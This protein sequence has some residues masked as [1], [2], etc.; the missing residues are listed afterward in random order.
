MPEHHNSDR[1]EHDLRLWIAAGQHGIFKAAFSVE[2]QTVCYLACAQET[3]PLRMTYLI[4]HP[5]KPILYGILRGEGFS[6]IHAYQI[7]DNGD[8][9]LINSLDDCPAG[10][11]HI[12]INDE[13]SLLVVAYYLSGQAGIYAILP[14]GALG[15]LR[16]EIHHSGSSHHPERQTSP[17]PHWT[18]FSLN[19]NSF[20]VTDLGIDQICCYHFKNNQLKLQQKT[21][22]TQGAGPRHMAFHKASHTAYVTNELQASVSA[23][24]YNPENG[25]L[26]EI[27]TIK[28]FV[29]SEPE[30][31]HNVSDIKIHPSGQFLYVLNRGVDLISVF[32]VA[33]KTGKLTWIASEPAHS[34]SSRSITFDA[35]GHLMFVSGEFSDTVVIFHINSNTGQLEWQPPILTVP[36]PMAIVTETIVFNQG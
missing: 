4:K 14:S 8:L 15:I 7:L 12:S 1:K 18:G 23:Y 26:T 24:R 16:Y 9:Q 31:P 32:Q 10:A 2:N 27:E 33:Q 34:T 22:T 5:D 29:K 35:E 6:Q 28:S 36:E 13:G 19:S 3:A 20:Y 21:L 30:R 25:Q 11:A 17:H